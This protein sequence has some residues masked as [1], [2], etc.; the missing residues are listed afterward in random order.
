MGQRRRKIPKSN[1]S[2][3]IIQEASTNAEKL[4]V[5]S[6]D[7]YFDQANYDCTEF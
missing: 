1:V 4:L 2:T 6:N 3:F 7:S 5:D